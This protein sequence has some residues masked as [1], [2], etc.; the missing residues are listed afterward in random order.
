[1]LASFVLSFNV[2]FL[3][4]AVLGIKPKANM[5]DSAACFRARAEEIG[6]TEGEILRAGALNVNTFGKFAFGTNY[7][8]GQAN[9]Q[10]L[11]AFISKICDEDPPPESRIPLIRR[12]FYEAYTLQNAELRAKIEKREDDPPRRLAQAKRSSRYEEQVKRLGG[13]DLT[14]EL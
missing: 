8:P 12:L 3:I 6:L 7:V 1:M 4:F 14:G 10:P 11:L 5:L 13:L 9:D 2:P